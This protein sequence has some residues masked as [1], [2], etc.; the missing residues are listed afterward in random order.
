MLSV[1]S[2]ELYIFLKDYLNCDCVIY[3]KNM[4]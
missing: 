4:T 2:V 1:M 3:Y